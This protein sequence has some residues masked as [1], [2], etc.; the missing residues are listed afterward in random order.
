MHKH[1]S[2]FAVTVCFTVLIGCCKEQQVISPFWPGIT[3]IGR[4]A[5]PEDDL[6][7]EIVCRRYA[8]GDDVER[9]LEKNIERAI[10]NCKIVKDFQLQETRKV[11][12]YAALVLGTAKVDGEVKRV[13]VLVG[14]EIVLEVI[15]F[16]D[17]TKQMSR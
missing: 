12:D 13:L 16:Y 9:N 11:S 4:G 5:T 2:I 14:I 8:A 1:S 7:L 3:E 15:T 6:D 10:S 17:V